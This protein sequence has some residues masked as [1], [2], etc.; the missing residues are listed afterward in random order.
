LKARTIASR[1]VFFDGR[2]RKFSG[3]RANKVGARL[4]HGGEQMNP[5]ER[6]DHALRQAERAAKPGALADAERWTKVAVQSANAAERL[7]AKPEEEDH[8]AQRDELFRRLTRFAEFSH[9]V[10]AWEEERDAYHAGL[11]HSRRT[12]APAP[13]PLRP[14]P[15]GRAAD[16]DAHLAYLLQGPEPKDGR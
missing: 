6:G 13:P 9:D 12:G 3:A 11:A 1:A 16:A 2:Y 7:A 4:L 5:Y 15:A 8:E 14:H 10:T